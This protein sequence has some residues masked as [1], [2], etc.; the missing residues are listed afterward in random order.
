MRNFEQRE[1][2]CSSPARSVRG[3]ASGVV[4][5]Q[6]ALF[7]CGEK[8]GSS[9]TLVETR[10]VREKSLPLVDEIDVPAVSKPEAMPE[11]SNSL[12]ALADSDGDGQLTKDEFMDYQ[13]KRR[14][15]RPPKTPPT[16]EEQRKLRERDASQPMLKGLRSTLLEKFDHDRDGVFSPSEQAEAE[17]FLEARKNTPLKDSI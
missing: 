2:V 11:S 17:K 14:P 8:S 7:G 10:E 13:A 5:L 1:I 9:G 15:A 6:F 4:A 12:V 3:V 16:P